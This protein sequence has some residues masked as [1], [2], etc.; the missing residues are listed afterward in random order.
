MTRVAEVDPRVF[1]LAPF[2]F[3][4]RSGRDVGYPITL[5]SLR[6]LIKARI[7]RSLIIPSARM[8]FLG[9]LHS[10]TPILPLQSNIPVM[11]KPDSKIAAS[12]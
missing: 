2:L 4:G 12:L 1:Q 9:T 7:S 8:A 11:S 3:I 6:L 10:E 5:I